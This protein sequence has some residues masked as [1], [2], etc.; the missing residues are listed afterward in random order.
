MQLIMNKTDWVTPFLAAL[1]GLTVFWLIW[2]VKIINPIDIEWTMSGDAAQHFLG[3]HFFRFEPWTFPLGGIKSFLY[4]EGT[5][6][7]YT[8]SIPLVAIPLKLISTFLPPIFQYRGPWILLCYMLQGY[9]AALLIGEITKNRVI[10]LLSSIFFLI[11]PILVVRVGMEHEAL[12]SH[13]LIIAS[14]YFYLQTDGV[15]NRTL[16]LL[17]LVMAALIHFYMLFMISTIFISYVLKVVLEN[18][19]KHSIFLF[20][21]LSVVIIIFFMWLAGYFVVDPAAVSSPIGF[22]SMNLLAP[23][24]NAGGS[25]FLKSYP[26]ATAGQYEGYNYWGF[27]LLL[28]VFLSLYEFL[29]QKNIF[30]PKTCIPLIF[31][32]IFLTILSVSNK[33][34]F[35]HMTLLEFD[36]PNLIKQLWGVVRSSGRL[37][38][39]VTYMVML[40]SL[41]VLIKNNAAKNT[42]F[43]VFILVCFQI[44]DFY[45]GYKDK[46]LIFTE[47]R[48]ESTLQSP[49]WEKVMGKIDHIAFVPPYREGDDYVPFALLAASYGKT[50]NVGYAA[51]CNFENRRRYTTAFIQH[52]KSGQVKDDTL[53]ILKNNLYDMPNHF[54][55]SYY[56]VVD[57]FSIMAPALESF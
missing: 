11:A 1:L 15:R 20:F 10:V 19:K 4:P 14:I 31:S 21:I 50:L 25:I 52:F 8:D 34:T 3:W 49:L 17:L 51:R 26:L 12:C 7:V 16:W 54:P 5:S 38:W 6:L 2:G 43:V 22:L 30:C 53:Y 46:D 45:P 28:M 32:A 35:S 41:T 55:E 36:P 18:E 13:W 57:G 24:N 44:A 42:M 39:P 23:I 29:R 33:V 9:F 48:W 27:G 47:K 40:A 56:K 37:F